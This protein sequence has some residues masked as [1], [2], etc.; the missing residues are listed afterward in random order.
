MR[1]ALWARGGRYRKNVKGL[2]GCPDI[3]FLGARLAIFC[4][5]DFWHGRDWEARRQ[6]LGRGANSAYWIAKIAGNLERDWRNTQ[7]LLDR[8]WTVL[9]IWES[10]VRS[11]PEGVA[12]GVV[13]ILRG[14][15]SRN[16]PGASGLDSC[17]KVA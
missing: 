11:D 14:K 7:E 3:V 1:K 16:R 5:G 15:R 17:E 12:D 9:H 2:P 10:D 13:A 4:D 8:G 6:K